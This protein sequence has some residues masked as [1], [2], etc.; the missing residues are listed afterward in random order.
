MRSEG[1]DIGYVL[2]FIV[3][4]FGVI[5]VLGREWV[6][7]EIKKADNEKDSAR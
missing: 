6:R 3:V 5:A 4:F 7:H 2:L 1:I